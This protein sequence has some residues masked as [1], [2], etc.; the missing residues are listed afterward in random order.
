MDS[1]VVPPHW[2]N[3]IVQDV[4]KEEQVI[5]DSTQ[6]DLLPELVW[7]TFRQAKGRADSSASVG[8]G[9]AI[10]VMRA[11]TDEMG[12]RIALMHALA[13]LVLQQEYH[14]L[15]FWN[16]FW[17]LSQAYDV[18]LNA[19]LEA[20]RGQNKALTAYARIVGV[21]EVLP[22]EQQKVSANV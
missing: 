1:T 6:P 11:G 2:A 13:H 7:K 5:V 19:A 20:T 9:G 22:G 18:D 21:K 12:Q 4:C 14:S 15:A 10:I 17:Q 16:R 8:A 3:Q